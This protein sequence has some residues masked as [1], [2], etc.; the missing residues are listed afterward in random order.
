MHYHNYLHVSERKAMSVDRNS[1]K[2]LYLQLKERIIKDIDSGKLKPGSFIQTEDELCREYGISR[3]PVRQALGEL[4][5]EGY[6][7]RTRGKGTS[8]STAANIPS[9]G[10]S[11]LLGLV[12]GSLSGGLNSRILE[13]FEKQAKSRG[14]LTASCSS[15]GNTDEEL[16]CIDMLVEHKCSGI[17]IFPSDESRISQKI[18]EI[19]SKG[20]YIGLLDRNPGISDIDY[21]GSDNLTGAYMAAR[22]LALQGFHNVVFI[23]QMSDLSSIVERMEGFKKGAEEFG[24]NMVTRINVTEDITRYLYYRQRFFV[25]KIYDE[26]TALKEH[27]PV[28][29]LALNDSIA[30][31]C[32]RVFDEQQM[33]IGTDVGIVGFDNI[34]ESGYSKVPLT[35][36]AQNGALIGQTAADCAIDK[37][38][39]ISTSVVKTLIPTQLVIRNSC[40]EGLAK[41]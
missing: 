27:L 28:G 21:V 10:E 8:V 11:K 41:F 39:G 31:H 16:K 30:L 12:L 29:V 35:T 26:L 13:G 34:I 40:G 33:S 6:L 23:A 38:E 1:N 5:K 2:P 36:V 18:D 24:L 17:F 14:Y 19:R 37:I 3:Y 15:F 25:E 22:H 7:E 9:F 20:V 4:V 32:M